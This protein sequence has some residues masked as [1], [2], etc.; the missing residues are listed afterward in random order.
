MNYFTKNLVEVVEKKAP[1]KLTEKKN[2]KPEKAMDHKR[3]F[4]IHNRKQQTPE[5][6]LK[7]GFDCPNADIRPTGPT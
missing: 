7:L 3:N 6:N 2:Q 5:K 4:D 1:L